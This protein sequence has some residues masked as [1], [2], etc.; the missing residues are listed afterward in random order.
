VDVYNLYTDKESRLYDFI[1]LYPTSM[2][3]NIFPTKLL[4]KLMGNP[5]YLVNDTSYLQNNI[6]ISFVNCERYAD[7]YLIEK[8]TKIRKSR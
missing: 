6:I 1:S 7:N 5:F 3:N 8:K 2:V 4:D